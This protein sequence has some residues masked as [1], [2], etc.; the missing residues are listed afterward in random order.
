MNAEEM[1]KML[2]VIAE[3]TG[4]EDEIRQIRLVGWPTVTMKSGKHFQLRRRLY[5][6]ESWQSPKRVALDWE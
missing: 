1:A 2:S 6:K 5:M 3:N 4:P